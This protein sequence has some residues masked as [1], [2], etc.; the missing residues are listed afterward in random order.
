M[1]A[2]TPAFTSISATTM[3]LREIVEPH[4]LIQT[5]AMRVETGKSNGTDQ[6]KAVTCLTDDR[7]FPFHMVA[8]TGIEPVT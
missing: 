6:K 5:P 4:P 8:T 3:P 7:L 2:L 1:P